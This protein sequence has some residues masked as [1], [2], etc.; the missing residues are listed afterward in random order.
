MYYR[1]NK[2]SLPAIPLAY[3]GIKYK[4]ECGKKFWKRKSYEKHYVIKHI[5][6]I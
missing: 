3:K 2:G 1:T 6:E 4:C 5:Y